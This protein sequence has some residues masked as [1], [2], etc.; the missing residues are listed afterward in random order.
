M[1]RPRSGRPHPLQPSTVPKVRTRTEAGF[2]GSGLASGCYRHLFPAHARVHASGAS[3][4]STASSWRLAGRAL[5]GTNLAA[6]R[7]V[8]SPPRSTSRQR[9]GAQVS[10]RERF[11]RACKILIFR[12]VP[13]PISCY[14]P[15]DG[16]SVAVSCRLSA[17]GASGPHHTAAFAWRSFDAG[18]SRGKAGDPMLHRPAPC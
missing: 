5:V 11:V 13:L 10:T 15:E 18:T 3:R 9:P 8:S 12:C 2:G 6:R 17:S 16:S 4:Y 7:A 1:R 14:L